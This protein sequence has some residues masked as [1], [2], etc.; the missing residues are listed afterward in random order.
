MASSTSIEAFTKDVKGK[1]N[2]QNEIVL[3]AMKR[4]GVSSTDKQILEVTALFTDDRKPLD[5]NVV[6]RVLHDLREF[7][8]K[9][10]YENKKNSEGRTV[11]HHYIKVEGKQISIF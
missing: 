7:D 3:Q 5:R 11:H 4:L 6:T 2:R 9:V 1:T 8:K 10:G